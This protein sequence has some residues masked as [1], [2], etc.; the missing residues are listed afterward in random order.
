METYEQ[1]KKIISKYVD[2]S[3]LSEN[4]LLENTGINSLDVVEI[5]AQI[6]E[7]FNIEL[8]SDE[9][10]SIKTMKDIVCLVEQKRK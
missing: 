8:T 6:E 5:S 4:D 1:I 7:V 9:I 2:V 3:H 10:I